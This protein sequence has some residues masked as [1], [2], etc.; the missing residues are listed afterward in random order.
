M[1]G[2]NKLMNKF[3]RVLGLGLM[4]ATFAFAGFAQQEEKTK[5]YNTYIEKYQSDKVADLQAALDA[6][7][8]Y[9]AKFNTPDD[10][11]QVTYFK[12]AI[13]T[14][15]A[16][17]KTKGDARLAKEE[18]DAWYALLKNVVNASNSKN[19]EQAFTLGK[20]AID[21]QFKY[22]GSGPLTA[23]IVKGQKLDIAIGL[24]VIGFD[25]AAVEKND[26][27]NNDALMFLKSAVQQLEAGQPADTTTFGKA[28]GYN[29]EN[30]DNA[31][32]L[33]NYYIG[34][35]MY[36]R[37]KKE[38]E[39]LPYFY[40]ATQYNS[41][42]R[43]F[44]AVYEK[45]GLKYYNRLAELDPKRLALI[46]A[47]PDKQDTPETIAML[48]E[49]KGVAD[50]GLEAYAKAIKMA[51]AD[52]KISQEYKDT[53]RANFEQLYKFRYGNTDGLEVYLNNAAGKSLTSPTT[54]VKPVVEEV[55]TVETTTTTT[56]PTPSTKPATTQVTTKTTETKTTTPMANGA[57][58]TVK[59]TT[60][61]T[62]E[63]PATAKK[64]RKKR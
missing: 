30:K 49:E 57:K 44:P 31:L 54:P 60:T 36:F 16:A 33:L 43:N 13:P 28:V 19:W 58:T 6:A 18:S 25:R 51:Q 56:S 27:F 40:K 32:G 46:E 12:E 53:L 34:Y 52:T 14:L 9:I 3:L 29:L 8:E 21:K 15:E 63:K 59:T 55:K 50:R 64:P 35:I 23:E 20:Q 10:E 1:L 38:E 7:K 45:I 26:N 17:I 22:L 2:G 4:I 39:A 62:E 5:L 48:A 47:A 42:A 37:Q 11:A 41:A 61:K 24:G